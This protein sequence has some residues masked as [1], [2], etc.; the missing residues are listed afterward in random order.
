VTRVGWIGL[1]A[2]GSA[3]APRLLGTASEL[4]VYDVMADRV[5]ALAERGARAADSPAAAAG[6]AEVLCLMVATPDQARQALF[7]AG[8]AAEALGPGAVV[9]VMSTIGPTAVRELAERLEPSGV[10]VLDAPVSGGTTRAEGGELVIMIGGPTERFEGVR[11]LLERL[12][13]T[14]VH[15]GEAV[16]DGQAVKVVNQ[17]LCGV[18]IAAAAEALGLAAALGLDPR[19]VWEV[20]RHGAAGSF[21]LDDRGARMLDGAFEPVRSA[22]DIFVKDMGLVTAAARAHKLPTPLADAAEQLYLMGSAEGLGRIDDAAVVKL[23][24]RWAGRLVTE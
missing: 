24:E 17:L 8:G 7:G 10:A 1:G 9:V 3:M 15:V 2:M 12:G 21:M 14:V 4:A 6:G 23:Y 20:I 11:P 16:G 22:L 13:T 5:R 19:A 18:H